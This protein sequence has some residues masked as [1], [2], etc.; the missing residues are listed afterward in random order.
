ME[1]GGEGPST[2]KRRRA[3][4]DGPSGGGDF[5]NPGDEKTISVRID[6]DVLDCVICFEPL[7]APVFQVGPLHHPLRRKSHAFLLFYDSIQN[8]KR[9]FSGV[10]ES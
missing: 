5:E 10:G 8:V 9:L 3:G 4:G 6:S 7:S 1:D 2:P